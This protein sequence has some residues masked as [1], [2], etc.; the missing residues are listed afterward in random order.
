MRGRLDLAARL[1]YRCREARIARAFMRIQE[2]VVMSQPRQRARRSPNRGQDRVSACPRPGARGLRRAADG[3][4]WL[5]HRPARPVGARGPDAGRGRGRQRRLGRASSSLMVRAPCCRG[6]ANCSSAISPMPKRASIRCRA[7][8]MAACRD[9]CRVRARFSPTCPMRTAAAWPG[10]GRRSIATPPEPGP[11][12]AC[13]ATTFRIST[14]RPTATSASTRPASTMP[15]WSRC[16]SVPPTPCA[17]RCSCPSPRKCADTTSASW[18]WPI[19]PAAP[20]V[21]CAW[22]AVPF[23]A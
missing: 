18:R 15:R 14:T 2:Q 22:R 20:D 5:V 1:T 9:C 19:L 7:M 11:R 13:R 4:R 12:P 17:G 10:T 8:P 6:C 21:S 16:S 3:P 23:R